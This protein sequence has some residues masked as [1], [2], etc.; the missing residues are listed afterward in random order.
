MKRIE[1][2]DICKG[3]G[4]ILVVLGHTLTTPV[5]QASTVG[6]NLYN[7]IYFFHMPLMLYLSGR[8][9]GM[10]VER[11]KTRDNV[12]MSRVKSLL[13]PYVIYNIFVYLVFCV[14]NMIGSLSGVLESSGYGK[15]SLLNF[16]YGMLIGDNKYSFH[17]WYI[18]ALFI[19]FVITYLVDR[20]IDKKV[21]K[22]A[23]IVLSFV[24]AASRYYINTATW[25][26]LNVF[27]QFYMYFLIGQ[28]IDFSKYAKKVPVI[29][30]EVISVP[31]TFLYIFKGDIIFKYLGYGIGS[32]L[33]WI[34][35]IGIIIICVSI[36]KY[37]ENVTTKKVFLYLGKKSFVIYMFHQ[38]FFGSGVGLVLM[39]VLNMP[40]LVAV[41]I[42]FILCFSV[43]L[44]I[45]E[46]YK[47]FDGGRK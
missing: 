5:R 7:I 42:S 21:V 8:A 17:M 35:V 30:F 25:G 46:G 36:S 23:L 15:M 32:I 47:R 37:I 19:M 33:S 6:M 43:P 22:I 20:Y 11:Y 41:I 4:M 28:Y 24:M 45:S 40:W 3:I 26:I 34:P 10:V 16:I 12:V 27:M 1:W 13:V 31:I 14:A 44:I 38:P 9:Y 29:I 39:K 18:Y 2:V